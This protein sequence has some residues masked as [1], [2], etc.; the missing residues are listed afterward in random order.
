MKKWLNN[1]LD[2]TIIVTIVIPLIYGVVH[3]S[4]I[5]YIVL[6]TGI[7]VSVLALTVVRRLLGNSEVDKDHE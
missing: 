6:M 1:V 2:S 3:R 4:S 5:V 7:L